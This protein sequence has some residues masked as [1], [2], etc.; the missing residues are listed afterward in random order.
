[1]ANPKLTI[2]AQLRSD[3]GKGASRRL[4]RAGEV[5]AI[6]YGGDS[7]PQIITLN[8]NQL[9]KQIEAEE[10]FTQILTII[11]NKTPQKVVLK[12][13]QRHPY[14][15]I[16]LHADFLRIKAD[17]ALTMLIPLHFINEAD[18]PGSQQGG[19][20]SHHISEIEISCLPANLPKYIEVDLSEL[21]LNETIHLSKLSLPKDVNLAT[22]IQDEEHD[23]ALV[24]M[25]PPRKIVEPEVA[26]AEVAAPEEL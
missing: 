9:L 1:M 6:I 17:E 3:M 25:H 23:Q 22:P 18:S 12:D 16:I 13:L 15:P 5:P 26:P 10:F 20:V 19:V 14:K 24:S 2:A 7:A 21:D 8:H 11:L 4:R